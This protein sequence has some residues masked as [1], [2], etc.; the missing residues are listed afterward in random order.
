MDGLD[1]EGT[2]WEDPS[3]PGSQ[4]DRP[5]QVPHRTPQRTRFEAQRGTQRGDAAVSSGRLESSMWV[6]SG[7]G[8][9]GWGRGSGQKEDEPSRQMDRG[10]RRLAGQAAALKEAEVAPEGQAQTAG[11]QK[12][13]PRRTL[14]ATQREGG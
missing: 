2:F 10:M 13:R 3:C 8:G 7:G 12:G 5:H 14:E 9:G 11:G 6:S 4:E 1:S